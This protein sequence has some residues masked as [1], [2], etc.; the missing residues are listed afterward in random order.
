MTVENSL[1]PTTT[2]GDGSTVTFPYNFMVLAENEL[3]V[4]QTVAATGEE[5]ILTITE[6]TGIGTPAGG[7]ITVAT[8]PTAGTK[9][10]VDSNITFT[11]PQEYDG[12]E[13]YPETVEQGLDRLTIQNQGQETRINRAI[14][15]AVSDVVAPSLPPAVQRANKFVGFGPDGTEIVM[16][17][18][19]A[20]SQAY[21]DMAE[22]QADRAVNAANYPYTSGE[23]KSAS[24]MPGTDE[25]LTIFTVD[26]ASAVAV[27]LPAI[28]SVASAYNIG[29]CRTTGS[30]TVTITADGSDLING[31]GG[32]AITSDYLCLDF[33]ISGGEWV[34]RDK[35]IVGV[36]IG[37]AAGN[38]VALDENSKLPAV[39]GSSLIG[40]SGHEIGEPFPVWDH[41]TGV[42]APDNSGASK[43]IVLT[44]GE[45]GVGE[46]NEGLVT[47]EVV[48]GSDPTITATVDIDYASSPIDGQTVD[49]IN[50]SRR[51]L[52]PGTSGTTA[53]SALG[54][55]THGVLTRDGGGASPGNMPLGWSSGGSSPGAA[56]AGGATS[57]GDAETRPRYIGATYYMRIA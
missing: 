55:H 20:A 57:T 39:D 53:D 33:T 41:I 24:F 14:R 11:Q 13:L 28:A 35:S 2:D 19:A 47:N 18:G 50:T 51:F 54:A 49:L 7:T 5:T 36:Q 32:I 34:V 52:R 44:A 16:T 30:G 3:Q 10:S 4:T 56:F 15:I 43:Y 31:S 46:Y 38:I 1:P 42:S 48:S 45:D 17:E 37:T 26:S 40:I 23:T 12:N 27:S 6:S 22:E 8:A 9:I 25:T 29:I 21:V